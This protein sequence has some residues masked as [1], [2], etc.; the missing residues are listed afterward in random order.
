MGK[1][2]Y[3]GLGPIFLL[4]IF[5]PSP[6]K[7]DT[8]FAVKGADFQTLMDATRAIPGITRT[9]MRKDCEEE[10]IK[11]MGT[12]LGKFWKGMVDVFS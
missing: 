3:Y 7:A 10:W 12:N 5:G 8:I 2:L 9:A 11:H 4:N 1:I 6:D